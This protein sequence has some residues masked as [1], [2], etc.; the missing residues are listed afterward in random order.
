[1]TS[2][3]TYES[4]YSREAGERDKKTKE[5]LRNVYPDRLYFPVED[6]PRGVEYRWVREEIRGQKDT[7]NVTLMCKQGWTPVPFSRHPHFLADTSWFK[8]EDPTVIRIDGL[9]LCERPIEYG[10]I[11]R[12]AMRQQ[13]AHALQA[14]NWTISQDHERDSRVFLNETKYPQRKRVLDEEVVRTPVKKPSR[15]RPKSKVI[16]SEKSSKLTLSEASLRHPSKS[17]AKTATAAPVFGSD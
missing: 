14:V 11:E 2:H 12:E 7:S 17:K 15:S 9:I 13:N 1:M 4:H 5:F 10:E 6:V 8:S 3:K 16:N